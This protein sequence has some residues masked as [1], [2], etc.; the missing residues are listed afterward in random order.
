[1]MT[2]NRWILL[3]W[4]AANISMWGVLVCCDGCKSG[5]SGAKTPGVHQVSNGRYDCV[6][7][8]G[9]LIEVQMFIFPQSHDLDARYEETRKWRNYQIRHYTEKLEKE[10]N[11]RIY[12]LNE[13]MVR[14]CKLGLETMCTSRNGWPI[15][16][17]STVYTKT[18]VPSK[19]VA[20]CRFDRKD[21]DIV[22][23]L[24]S[25]KKLDETE[26]L[27][28]IE[29]MIQHIEGWSQDHWNDIHIESK[30]MYDEKGEIATDKFDD[31]MKDAVFPEQH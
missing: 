23:L 12:K 26:F 17:V 24:R 19:V 7:N 1:M 10:K 2:I 3:R 6:L 20:E 11:P 21:L 18:G 9:R 4:I 27:P 22:F 14:L 5:S 15:I 13:E 25:P 8:D 16:L 31:F 29:S 28:A 30:P